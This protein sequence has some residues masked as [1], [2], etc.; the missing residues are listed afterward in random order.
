KLLSWLISV[1]R[2]ATK[3]KRK[4]MSDKSIKNQSE[5]AIISDIENGKIYREG[6]YHSYNFSSDV[7]DACID[8]LRFSDPLGIRLSL[9]EE[10]IKLL[11]SKDNIQEKFKIAEFDKGNVIAAYLA[12]YQHYSDEDI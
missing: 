8:S 10:I 1:F 4:M 2:T 3:L 7:T 5:S 12:T 6:A 11:D 9:G